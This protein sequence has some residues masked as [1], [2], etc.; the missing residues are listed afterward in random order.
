MRV[1][2]GDKMMSTYTFVEPLKRSI[3]YVN[4]RHAIDFNICPFVL[5][6]SIDLHEE[7]SNAISSFRNIDNIWKQMF[8]YMYNKLSRF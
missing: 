8:H 4:P 1:F 3:G 5:I 6:R 7:I 2:T